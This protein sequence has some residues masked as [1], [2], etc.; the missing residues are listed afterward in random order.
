MAITSINRDITITDMSLLTETGSP[1]YVAHVT[2]TA[3]LAL[4]NGSR[5]NSAAFLAN[6]SD[7]S[8]TVAVIFKV[9][10][11]SGVGYIFQATVTNN[12]ECF[13]EANGTLQFS[14]IGTGITTKT[15]TGTFDDSV[16]RLGIFHFNTDK[17]V[18]LH[19]GPFVKGGTM[20]LE[21][22][23]AGTDTFSAFS[24][25]S[26]VTFNASSSGT[27]PLELNSTLAAPSAWN[28][29]PAPDAA[30]CQGILDAYFAVPEP[31]GGRGRPNFRKNTIR[32]P[33]WMRGPV[34]F[35]RGQ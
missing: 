21:A 30:D 2:G 10:P 29:Q 16:E 4:E 14:A 1:S 20:V 24:T 25:P 8:V 13:V 31:V 7:T 33:K 27:F 11:N 6:A 34:R 17:T 3:L 32:Q 26:L 18:T 9:L 5:V 15:T 19:T 28:N 35:K 23:A 12:F 22:V